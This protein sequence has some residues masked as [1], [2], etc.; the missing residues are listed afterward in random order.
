MK[1]SS[2]TRGFSSDSFPSACL[3]LSGGASSTVLLP[4]LGDALPL[5]LP[6]LLG[7]DWLRRCPPGVRGSTRLIAG[8]TNRLGDRFP[9]LRLG[10]LPAGGVRILGSLAELVLPTALSLLRNGDGEGLTPPQ[11]MST[12]SR[13]RGSSLERE[14][15]ARYLAGDSSGTRLFSFGVETDRASL[16]KETSDL[17]GLSPAASSTGR[18]LAG[19]SDST[20]FTFSSA[21]SSGWG[22]SGPRLFLLKQLPMAVRRRCYVWVYSI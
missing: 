16:Q 3:L 21:G 22:N 13:L 19:V 7:A 5:L 12:A 20:S 4:R 9:G 11:L 15:F 1:H 17:T 6:I 2:D 10:T 8:D 18:G 14:R